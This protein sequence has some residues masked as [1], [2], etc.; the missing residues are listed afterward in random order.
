MIT[1]L[2]KD[3]VNHVVADKGDKETEK[4]YKNS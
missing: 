3:S 4:K 1:E 2:I